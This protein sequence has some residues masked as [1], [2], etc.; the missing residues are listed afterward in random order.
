MGLIGSCILANPFDFHNPI[1]ITWGSREYWIP[2]N[3]LGSSSVCFLRGLGVGFIMLIAQSE[4]NFIQEDIFR[5]EIKENAKG[6]Q[7]PLDTR[8]GS[9]CWAEGW[10]QTIFRGPFQPQWFCNSCSRLSESG[11]AS[12]WAVR[13]LAE[14]EWPR[15]PSKD[16]TGIYLFGQSLLMLCS[17]IWPHLPE[18]NALINN[19]WN[20]GLLLWIIKKHVLMPKCSVSLQK[21]H[22]GETNSLVFNS[23]FCTRQ[24][25]IQSLQP[26]QLSSLCGVWSSVKVYALLNC[27]FTEKE[28]L[29][30]QS[31][32]SSG[33]CFQALV[34]S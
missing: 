4:K 7:T 2:E 6:E 14:F 18:V 28:V 25:I 10:A 24:K 31:F 12:F 11:T 13:Q 23:G 8:L 5:E 16:L 9:L 30:S 20:F 34:Y 22:A 26:P 32:L 19:C 29:K 21:Q 33:N 17:L 27:S 15:R 3:D 1:C